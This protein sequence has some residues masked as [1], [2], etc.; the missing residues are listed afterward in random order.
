M[1]IS[2]KGIKLAELLNLNLAKFSIRKK[3][4]KFPHHFM[5]I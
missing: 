4:N 1:V 5:T 2:V 3:M